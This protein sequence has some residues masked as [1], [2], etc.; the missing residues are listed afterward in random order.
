M[1]PDFRQSCPIYK[2]VVLIKIYPLCIH[3]SSLFLCVK[4]SKEGVGRFR[5]WLLTQALLLRTHQWNDPIVLTTVMESG[6]TRIR[7]ARSD[8]RINV[9]T[10]IGDSNT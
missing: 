2:T 3:L 8:A 4:I 1:A 5:Q 10:L 6:V 7:K 9:L